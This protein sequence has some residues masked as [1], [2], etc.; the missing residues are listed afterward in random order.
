MNFTKNLVKVWKKYKKNGSGAKNSNIELWFFYVV[1]L[2][3]TGR[4]MLLS[5]LKVW[6]LSERDADCWKYKKRIVQWGCKL[7]YNEQEVGW[8]WF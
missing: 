5:E 1:D 2:I 8:F 7:D 3:H 4:V 6:M